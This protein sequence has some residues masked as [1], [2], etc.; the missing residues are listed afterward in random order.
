MNWLSKTY[1]FLPITTYSYKWCVYCLK[2]LWYMF[3]NSYK[4]QMDIVEFY[5]RIDRLSVENQL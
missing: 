1:Y 3:I 4:T 2:L 5:F